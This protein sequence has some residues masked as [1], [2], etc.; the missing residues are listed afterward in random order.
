MFLAFSSTLYLA[1][2]LESLL[3]LSLS[4]ALPA[5][6]CVSSDQERIC[7][8]VANLAQQYLVHTAA[9]SDYDQS[10]PVLPRFGWTATSPVRRR[11]TRSLLL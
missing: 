2:Y 5:S 4:F 11:F 1:I 8:F 7:V 9:A 10:P 3:S 6:A